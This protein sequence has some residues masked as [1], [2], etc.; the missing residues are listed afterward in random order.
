MRTKNIVCKATSWFVWRAVGMACLFLGFGGYFF[1]DGVVGYPRANEAFFT[2]QAFARA[3][4]T[5]SSN[6]LTWRVYLQ[7]N[8]MWKTEM[9]GETP[10][11]VDEE[12]RRC[13]LPTAVAPTWPEEMTDA[14]KVGENN[15][16]YNAWVQ[17]SA[18]RKFSVKPAEHAYDAGAVRE[19]KIAG[20]ICVAL[21]MG[22]LFL[23]LRTLSRKL[24]F[25]DGVLTVAGKT[26]RTDEIEKIDIRLWK[27]KGLA[28]LYVR[29]ANGKTIK[30]RV[31]GMAYGGF[32]KDRGEPAEQWMQN[33]L[34]Q[35]HGDIVSYDESVE[36]QA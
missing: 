21:A 1:Y 18:R 28:W 11:A 25:E 20:C 27:L 8:P 35:F 10:Y 30:L 3:G 29:K 5:V 32:G 34:T 22:C 19:Q 24:S 15:G 2:Y 23:L 7:Q 33:V 13:P 9:Y 26:F 12:G 16:W 4:Q 6:G 36:K 31:D 14:V 17:Y